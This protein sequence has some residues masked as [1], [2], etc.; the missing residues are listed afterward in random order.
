[1]KSEKM[2]LLRNDSLRYLYLCSVKP[3][4]HSARPHLRKLGHIGRRADAARRVKTHAAEQIPF[5]VEVL[6]AGTYRFRRTMSQRQVR[7][8]FIIGV[9]GGTASG[10]TSVCKPS[11][12]FAF[13]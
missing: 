5:E 6:P 11:H 13:D 2:A 8:P 1:M 12:H 3:H 4:G 7:K 10:K 9:A